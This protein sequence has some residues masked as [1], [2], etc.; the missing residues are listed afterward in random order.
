MRPI[1]VLLLLVMAA[2]AGAFYYNVGVREAVRG[3]RIA[4]DDRD[5][6]EAY[7]KGKALFKSTWEST[8]NAEFEAWGDDPSETATPVNGEKVNGEIWIARGHVT[9]T[10]NG[11]KETKQWCL[12][13]DRQKGTAV[14][15]AVGKEAEDTLHKI[16]SG[17]LQK[18]VV[19]NVAKP[20]AIATPKPAGSWMWEKEG[21]GALD[22][23]VKK[24][25]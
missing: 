8:P 24:G 16:D 11:S 6:Y 18:T 10:N 21:R 1:F 14:G 20:G 2:G 9:V 25:R 22:A 5:R 15:R 13:F 7:E 12:A 19:Q 4:D 3:W 23:P 17:D